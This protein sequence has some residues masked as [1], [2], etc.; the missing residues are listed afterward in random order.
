MIKLKE[1]WRKLAV[2]ASVFSVV[3]GMCSAIA[4]PAAE[5]YVASAASISES[6]ARQIALRNAGV[7][8]SKA[9]A[10]DSSTETTK[11]RST[12]AVSFYKK[13]SETSYTHYYYNIN[14]SNGSIVKKSS[15]QYT[16][17]SAS[18][19][20][21]IALDDAG[22]SRSEVDDLSAEFDEDDGKLVWYVSFDAD[23]DDD[24]D[25][26]DDYDYY[27]YSNGTYYPYYYYG[28]TYSYS[29]RTYYTE[30]NGRVYYYDSDGNKQYT[31]T[32][33]YYRRSKDNDDDEESYDYVI[34]AVNENIISD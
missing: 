13:N 24:D 8:S 21:D 34:N 7:S 1:R 14:K 4:A 22:F 33:V 10:L 6:K 11:G 27:Y 20:K 29:G 31:T 30:S 16:T 12:F 32:T 19:A 18:R 3:L 23:D 28:G 5:G 2:V 25:D 26:D 9:Y 15:K 17:I